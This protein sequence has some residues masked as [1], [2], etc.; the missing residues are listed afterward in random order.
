M[1]TIPDMY[2]Y[3]LYIYIGTVPDVPNI[4]NIITIV[5]HR[6]GHQSSLGESSGRI[7][8]ICLSGIVF[9]V[10]SVFS[11]IGTNIKC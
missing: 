1:G 2:I 4:H 9:R 3:I 11:K 7:S 6:V 10:Y 8:T 5:G